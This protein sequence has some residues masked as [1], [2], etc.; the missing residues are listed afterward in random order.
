[1]SIK[2]RVFKETSNWICKTRQIPNM[3]SWS[4]FQDEYNVFNH[5]D[6]SCRFTY[7]KADYIHLAYLLPYTMIEHLLI[8]PCDPLT[9]NQ[10]W[11]FLIITFLS[12]R[13]Q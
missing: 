4:N 1:M 12:S 10:Y 11:D 8:C 6:F 3:N 2:F 13:I 5:P 7:T 9:N